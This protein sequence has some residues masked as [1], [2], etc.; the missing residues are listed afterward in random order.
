M[1][2]LVD[3]NIGSSVISFLR[4]KSFNVSSIAEKCPGITDREIL[5]KAVKENRILITADKDFGDLIFYS[6]RTHKGIILLRLKDQSSSAKIE[7]IDKLLKFH[8]GKIIKRFVVVTKDKVK[9]R[10]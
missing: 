1:K 9:I 6:R 8:R 4:N 7:V 2:F 5:K 3:E 10:P